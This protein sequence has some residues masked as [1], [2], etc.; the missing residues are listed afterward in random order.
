MMKYFAVSGI[1]NS[2]RNFLEKVERLEMKVPVLVHPTAYL[3]PSVV[4]K[5]GTVVEPG[6]IIN[7][8]L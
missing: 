4:V 5:A 8:I 6:A 1:I 7:S 2:G 3:S